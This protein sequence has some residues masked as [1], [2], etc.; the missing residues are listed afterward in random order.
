MT[1][2]TDNVFELAL[3]GGATANQFTAFVLKGEQGRAAE[4]DFEWRAACTSWA[5]CS[6]TTATSHRP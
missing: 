6:N 5:C 4:H 3:I 1:S 2:N